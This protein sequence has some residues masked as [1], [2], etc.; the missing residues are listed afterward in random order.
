MQ[1]SEINSRYVPEIDC[2]S[3]AQKVAE[4]QE[5]YDVTLGHLRSICQ[6]RVDHSLQLFRCVAIWKRLI[7]NG[8][9]KEIAQRTPAIVNFPVQGVDVAIML[10]QGSFDP[11]VVAFV[12]LSTAGIPL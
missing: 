9:T 6:V 1:S 4:D 3:Q 8:M 2:R 12:Y 10:L 11:L 5:L 7:G